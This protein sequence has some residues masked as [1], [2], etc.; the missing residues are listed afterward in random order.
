MI[1]RDYHRSIFHLLGR[2]ATAADRDTQATMAVEALVGDF[3]AGSAELWLAE[4]GSPSAALVASATASDWRG[5]RSEATLTRADDPRVER[6]LSGRALV[7]D[8]DA[9]AEDYGT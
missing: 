6:A 1:E 2:L 9:A 4:A 7:V 8:E 3:G 5:R